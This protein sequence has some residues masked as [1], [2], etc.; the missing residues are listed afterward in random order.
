MVHMN[1]I[2]VPQLSKLGL[3]LPDPPL[4]HEAL[5]FTKEH[6]DESIFNHVVRCAYWALIIAKRVPQ[7][8]S[9]PADLETVVIICILHD[10]GLSKSDVLAGLSTDKRFEVDGANIARSFVVSH[11]GS[12]SQWDAARID[13]LWTA[14]ALHTTPS[15]ALHAAPEVALANMAI[16]ADFAGVNWSHG[17]RAGLISLEE[18]LAV[19]NAFPRGSFNRQGLKEIMC[20][21][22][23]RK[24]ETTYDNFVGLFGRKYGYDGNGKGR[25]EYTNLWEEN[26]VAEILLQ[27]LDAVDALGGPS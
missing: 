26:Q 18:Y 14:I 22:C 19:T 25:E 13:Q 23:Q 27:G 6:C 11:A 12:D 7:F 15:I 20:G 9:Q 1:F 5:K 3:T 17:G 4:V 21:L 16:T 24:P 10:M 2:T 8:S